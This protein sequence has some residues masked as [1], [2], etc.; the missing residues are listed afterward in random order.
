MK[1]IISFYKKHPPNE[2]QHFHPELKLS[3][4]G[5]AAISIASRYSE[6][7]AESSVRNINIYNQW[8][9]RLD[10]IGSD[11]FITSIDF[12]KMEIFSI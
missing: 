7:W 6:F 3:I 9:E 1:N 12:V 4:S 5:I 2:L 8:E 11:Y 10:F